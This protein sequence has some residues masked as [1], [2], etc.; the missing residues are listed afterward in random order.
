[1]MPAVRAVILLSLSA[2]QSPAGVVV[3]DTDPSLR[4]DT[5]S[6]DTDDTD[7]DDTGDAIPGDVILR[8]NEFMASNRT[9]VADP[10]GGSSDW[11]ELVNLGEDPVDLDG[12]SLV[13]DDAGDADRTELANLSLAPGEHLLLWADGNRSLGP[14]H[15]DFTLG[16]EG[17]TLTIEDPAG[18]EHTTIWWPEQA[19]DVA[20][21]RVGDGAEHWVLT[22]SPTPGEANPDSGSDPGDDPGDPEEHEPCDLGSDLTDPNLWEGESVSFTVA[23]T[24]GLDLDTIEVADVRVPPSADFDGRTLEWST[25]PTDGGRHDLVLSVRPEG[26]HAQIPEAGSVTVWV[27]DNPELDGAEAPVAADYLEEWGLPVLHLDPE[28]SLSEEYVDTTVTYDGHA[29]DGEMKIRG[30][31][32]VSYPKNSFTL[33]FDAE[34]LD[35]ED[36]GRQE[37]LILTSTFDDN[38]YIR[39]KLTF[40]LWKAM[41]EYW[42]ETRILPR[43]EFVVVYLSGEYHGLYLATDRIDEDFVDHQGFARGGNMYKSVNH[44]ANFYSTDAGGNG[45]DTWHD[46]YE[47]KE[48]EPEDDFSD[49]DGFVQWTATN[50]S[51]TVIDGFDEWARLDEFMDWFLLVHFAEVQDSAGKNVYLYSE[52]PDDPDFHLSPWDFNAAW[53]QSWTTKRVDSDQLQTYT[54][55]NRVFKA[56]QEVPEA[57]DA[58]WERHAAMRADGPFHEDWFT[59]TIDAYYD[60]I[61]L[62]AERDWAKWQDQYYSFSRWSSSRTSYDD[63][64]DFEGE[65]AYVTSWAL[66]RVALFDEEHPPDAR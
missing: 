43:S 46:G 27:A 17:G 54:W 60:H 61:E 31:S 15:L 50:D 20:A 38:A 28:S 37:H 30:A 33:D 36:W 41:G 59:S 16:R 8:V 62:S 18:S 63:W 21:A 34:E 44:D 40:D 29:Y 52:D 56:I 10:L 49:I 11:L 19:T 7:V 32:S 57:E 9:S 55:H 23:C 45:K 5:G 66:D 53:G 6:V 64:Q 48:G 58:L 24:G 1:M 22:D 26:R 65:R 51:Q 39:Q 12:W 42:G 4:D 35:F 14:D 3:G 2:C 25:G 13:L 47:K